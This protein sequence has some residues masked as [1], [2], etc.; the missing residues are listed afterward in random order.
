M[1]TDLATNQK[2]ASVSVL[3]NQTPV[4]TSFPLLFQVC[5]SLRQVSVCPSRMLTLDKCPRDEKKFRDENLIFPSRFV[6][7]SH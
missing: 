3:T 4:L 7:A 5:A 2:T 1:P 6:T